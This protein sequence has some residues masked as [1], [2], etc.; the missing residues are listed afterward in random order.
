M[1]E[2]INNWG[3]INFIII[4]LPFSMQLSYKS[5]NQGQC[6]TLIQ[7]KIIIQKLKAMWKTFLHQWIMAHMYQNGMIQKKVFWT[8]RNKFWVYS[9]SWKYLPKCGGRLNYS[10]SLM[11]CRDRKRGRCC[12]RRLDNTRHWSCCTVKV[13][14]AEHER[15]DER[16][17]WA[18]WYF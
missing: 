9:I 18:A 11:A 4:L 7:K 8:I 16:G 14:L 6:P 3:F 13:S 17:G 12:C 15:Q 2:Q 1:L 5:S 10:A